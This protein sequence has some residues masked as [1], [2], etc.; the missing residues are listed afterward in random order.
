M[1]Q[2]WTPN[3]RWVTTA[4]YLAPLPAATRSPWG[5]I[6]VKQEGCLATACGESAVNWYVF[7]N[8]PFSV[9]DADACPRCARA[10]SVIRAVA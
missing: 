7:W 8:M 9:D 6:H 1:S 3:T 10:V 5:T 4:P 2:P